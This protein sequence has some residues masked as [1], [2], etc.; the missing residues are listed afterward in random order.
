M[1]IADIDFPNVGATPGS[2]I[3]IGAIVSGVQNEQALYAAPL[4]STPTR[5]AAGGGR[6]A[7]LRTR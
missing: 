5:R 7:R 4:A 1:A 6:S 3:A 2:D